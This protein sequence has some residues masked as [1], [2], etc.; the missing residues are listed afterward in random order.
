MDEIT[1]EQGQLFGS[2]DSLEPAA[3]DERTRRIVA[4]LPAN[5]RLGTSSWHFP[6]WQ[7][8]VWRDHV[9]ARTLSR[10]GLS[11]YAKHGLFQT[12]SV[13]RTYYAPVDHRTL[14]GYAAQVGDDFRFILKVGRDV[15]EPRVDGTRNPNF[16]SV[17]RVVRALLEPALTGMGEKLGALHLQLSPGAS[18]LFGQHLDLFVRRLETFFSALPEGPRWVVELRHESLWCSQVLDALARLDAVPCLSV[19]PANPGASAQAEFLGGGWP[20]LFVRWNLG[21][22]QEYKAAKARYAPFDRIV[23]ADIQTRTSLAAIIASYLTQQKPVYV[24][25][26]NKAEGSA[27]LTLLELAAEIVRG[28]H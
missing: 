4:A 7:G 28:D 14:G 25:A 13:D 6:G 5:L 18:R 21:A 24:V 16:L 9:P 19:H 8:L 15:T 17:P 27:P 22:G 1:D 11:A 10:V 20:A 12:V 26:N 2:N 3:V 23:D